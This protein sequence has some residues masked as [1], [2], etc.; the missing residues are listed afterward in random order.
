MGSGGGRMDTVRLRERL[1]GSASD[2]GSPAADGQTRA[3]YPDEDGFVERDGVSVY[4]ERYGD[5]Q[6]AILLLPTWSII[7]SRFWKAQIPY[8]ARHFR[9]VTFDGRGNG[10]SDRPAVT[11]AYA[12]TE[13]VADGLAV[14][15][16]TGTD[17]AIVVGLSMGGGY[18]LRLAAEHAE[19]VLGAV[20]IGPSLPMGIRWPDRETYPF[21]AELDTDAGWAR[22]N[23]FVWRRD[24]HGFAE[25]FIDQVF[26]EP[27]STKPIED[28]VGWAD[29]TDGETMVIAET[30]PYLVVSD[31]G[32][33]LRGKAATLALAARVTAPCLVVHGTNDRITPVGVGRALAAALGCPF[34]QLDGS[35]HGPDMRDPVKVNLL[36]RDFVRQVERGTR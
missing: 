10:R 34:V 21:D 2:A 28:G 25:F 14:L 3:R 17:R 36:I 26:S 20:F 27:H 22:Y 4:W 13:F 12:D 16:A 23:A 7:H 24:W 5:G 29:E 1:A 32:A 6:P 30:A 33:D 15:D 18:A 8:L 9:V 11:A 31:G 19:R 35:G